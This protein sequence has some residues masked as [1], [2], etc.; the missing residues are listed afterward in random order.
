[1]IENADIIVL[2]LGKYNGVHTT[3]F[4][5]FW[6]WISRVDTDF[7]DKKPMFFASTCI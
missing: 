2:S 5:N 1:M 4:K 7:W 6:N 3:S